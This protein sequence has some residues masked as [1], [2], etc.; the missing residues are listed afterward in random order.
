[1][2]HQLCHLTWQSSSSWNDARS[3]AAAGSSEHEDDDALRCAACQHITH[4]WSLM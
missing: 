2:K 1:M 3:A 4:S